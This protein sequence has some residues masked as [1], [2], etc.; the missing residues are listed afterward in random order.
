MLSQT[1][2]SPRGHWYG[3]DVAGAVPRNTEGFVK[4]SS[5]LPAIASC[6]RCGTIVLRMSESLVHPT[7][8]E[9]ETIRNALGSYWFH[10]SRTKFDGRFHRCPE[11]ERLDLESARRIHMHS[12]MRR[13]VPLKQSSRSWIVALLLA[14]AFCGPPGEAGAGGPAPPGT[15]GETSA[16]THRAR[17]ASID[18]SASQP[19]WLGLELSDGRYQIIETLGE[20]A[21]GST[22]RARDRDVQADVDIEVPH[23][24]AVGDAA[25]SDRFIREVRG[26]ANLT[27]PHLVKVTEVGR[28]RDSPFAVA[29]HLS[30][31]SLRFRRPTERDGRPAPSSP[32][33]L[34]A[35][36]PD[37]AEALDFLHSRG[38]LHRDVRPDNILFDERGQAYLGR[39]ALA[40]GIASATAVE[41]VKGPTLAGIT[42]GPP[43]YMAPEQVSG[44]P[45]DGR[46]DQYALAVIVYEWLSGRRPFQGHT[47]MSVLVQQLTR[48]PPALHRVR[49]GISE[50]L[51][52]VVERALSRDPRQRFADCSTFARAVL[53]TTPGRGPSPTTTVSN[54]PVSRR[55]AAEAG[56]AKDL[57]AGSLRGPILQPIQGNWAV[58]AMATAG[59]MG[60]ILLRRPRAPKVVEQPAAEESQA[61]VESLHVFTASEIGYCPSEVGPDSAIPSF[62]LL[63]PVTSGPELLDHDLQAQPLALRSS[64]IERFLARFAR[65]R[66]VPRLR[67]RT[68]GALVKPEE[69][70][71]DASP[72]ILGLGTVVRSSLPKPGP[73]Q[74]GISRRHAG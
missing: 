14:I 52:G 48:E 53:E 46:A 66:G 12:G 24:P 47:A 37:V 33:T 74:L 29:E 15:T 67:V 1:K 36:L 31:G 73:R 49:P 38:R 27:H 59:L 62:P 10:H 61:V 21:S 71:N 28:R 40:E 50:S 23:R 18:G 51:S 8:G 65:R 2:P 60:L 57:L 55:Q 4:M 63:Y 68:S 5:Q 42:M 72:A 20:G 11:Y 25:F 17:P 3:V 44:Q 35:W 13:S 54:T 30:G 34:L 26:L 69:S 41:P 9:R 22:Y 58:L 16:R 6:P 70:T 7:S 43:G 39:L 64:R 32:E 45:I 19:A 56:G